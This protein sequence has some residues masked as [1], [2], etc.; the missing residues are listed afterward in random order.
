MLRIDEIVRL[1]NELKEQEA[2][3]AQETNRQIADLQRQIDELQ[4]QEN[5]RRALTNSEIRNLQYYK[6][7][8]DQ[9]PLKQQ[10][11]SEFFRVQEI[12]ANKLKAL[13]EHLNTVGKESLS[14]IGERAVA[15]IKVLAAFQLASHHYLLVK[16]A[17]VDIK[18]DREQI[19]LNFDQHI[20]LCSRYHNE[21]VNAGLS[22]LYACDELQCENHVQPNPPYL[23][24]K[25]I[26]DRGLSHEYDVVNKLLLLAQRPV[27]SWGGPAW[28]EKADSFTTKYCKYKL[29]AI[30]HPEAPVRII[31]IDAMK[32]QVDRLETG[33]RR[34]G[35]FMP[36]PTHIETENEEASFAFIV[37]EGFTTLIERLLYADGPYHD[38]M[39]ASVLPTSA[40]Q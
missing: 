27:T 31:T 7:I 37:D 33:S 23:Y 20:E 29:Y 28:Q 13:D 22:L 19:E 10:V 38:M 35:M 32:K 21:V 6:D 39:Y 12:N 16:Y 40:P 2:R 15:I 14:L 24:S 17:G 3:R 8:A 5:E 11:I 9:A 34:G 25:Q 4:R 26:K 1:I 36:R 18:S 30:K